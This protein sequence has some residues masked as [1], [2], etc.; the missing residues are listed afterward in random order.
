MIENI[1]VAIVAVVLVVIV[2]LAAKRRFCTGAKKC[3]KKP[4]RRNSSQDAYSGPANTQLYVGNISYRASEDDLEDFFS[5]FGEIEMI[6]VIK[7]RRTGR[8]KGFAFITFADLDGASAALEA[9]EQ[10]LS[11][12]AL[13]VRYAKPAGR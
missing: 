7:D 11:G 4:Q 8:S 9:H 3:T 5:G 12:R 2:V 10:E 6:R 1:A 13:I